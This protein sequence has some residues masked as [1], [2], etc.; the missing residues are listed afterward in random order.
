MKK[1]SFKISQQGIKDF[2][3]R[4][5]E[6]L[7][8]ALSISLVAVFFWLG[9]KTPEYTDTDP[10]DLLKKSRQA[11]DY[12]HATD[13]WEKLAA[14][15][16]PLTNTVDQIRTAQPVDPDRLPYRQM[17]GTGLRMLEKRTDPAFLVP[18]ELQ[19]R[20]FRAQVMLANDQKKPRVAANIDDLPDSVLKY[21]AAQKSESFIYRVKNPN[22]PFVTV[23]A[24]V[25][26]A[27]IDYEAQ[28]K[29]YRD[30]FQYQRGYDAERDKPEYAFIE[31]QRK[32]ADS[33]WKPIT[34]SL[35]NNY[36]KMGPTAKDLVLEKIENVTMDIP[37]FL[38]ID[39]REL[40]TLPEM[41]AVI[42]E[43]FLKMQEQD[44]KKTGDEKGDDSEDTGNIFGS[45]NASKPD[46][47]S[48]TDDKSAGETDKKNVKYRLI[49][50]YDLDPKKYGDEYFYRVRLW[51]KDPN[52]PDAAAASTKS[53]SGSLKVGGG[54][55]G[56]S[57]DEGPPG[58]GDGKGSNKKKEL[59]PLYRDDLSPEVR[60]RLV[61]PLP[62]VEG[63][64]K[65]IEDQK[66]IY[67]RTVIPGEWVE[68][69]TPVKVT[70]GFETFVAGPVDA[71]TA[72]R[73]GE[74]VFYETEPEATV[75]VN[76][77]QEDLGVFVPALT[78]TLPGSVLNFRKVTN[79]LHP[80]TLEVKELFESQ[81]RTRRGEEKTGRLFNTD[82]ILV[83]AMGGQR[84]PFSRRPDTFFAPA[85]VL[86]MDRNG[87][88]IVRN[89]FNDETSFRHATFESPANAQAIEEASKKDDSDDDDNGGTDP[90]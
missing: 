11:N 9:F 71:P 28:L 8:F 51:F 61:A 21:P 7:F 79:L 24:V 60:R 29:A 35:F 58:S 43:E 16:V 48:K 1:P 82:A 81:T 46:E 47:A 36:E 89:V 39:Y 65:W 44:Q 33:E 70:R 54:G 38:G 15:R 41:K 53:S 2:F 40:V 30:T 5:S 26:M 68:S 22:V 27:L 73:I 64:P 83:D 10:A 69:K 80:I 3:F 6:K 66:E 85:E 32:T 90:G 67:L 77:F 34:A 20:F 31:V 87:R 12:I 59:K 14:H 17:L 25:G 55:G 56:S 86:L 13:S 18:G 84:Q 4:H 42:I 74:T 52:N 75:V 62:E 19:T 45:D 57:L 49:R 76:S 78:T 50:F 23:N 88:L 72:N 37:P 63:L